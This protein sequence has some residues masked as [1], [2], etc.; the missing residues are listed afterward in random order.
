MSTENRRRL[1]AVAALAV[2][3]FLALTLL[4]IRLT[5]PIGAALGPALWR[6]LGL[7]AVGLP[8]LGVLWGLAGLGR[9]RQLD[10]LPADG[11]RNSGRTAG[12]MT[13]P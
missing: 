7:G 2:G 5:G 13:G 9:L 12:A 10:P 6:G 8:L 11:A 1:V 3:L 4:P